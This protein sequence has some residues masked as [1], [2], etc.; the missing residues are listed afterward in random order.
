MLPKVV[1]KVENRNSHCG[2]MGICFKIFQLKFGFLQESLN[3]LFFPSCMNRIFTQ[4]NSPRSY[5]HSY[6]LK[7]CLLLCQM[8]L[9]GKSYWL[10]HFI[11][12]IFHYSCVGI[13]QVYAV[14]AS[15]YAVLHS[16]ETSYL[17]LVA[18]FREKNTFKVVNTAVEEVFSISLLFVLMHKKDIITEVC[19]NA[20]V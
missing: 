1:K 18:W 12:L 14:C 8:C 19:K 4:R 5:V 3:I 16:R 20:E 11:A 15:D 9:T 2:K 13:L 10:F 7:V 17:R 6:I